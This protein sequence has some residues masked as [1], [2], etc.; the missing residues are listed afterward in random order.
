MKK[1]ISQQSQLLHQ[2]AA[3]ALFSFISFHID[4]KWVN[5]TSILF[6]FQLFCSDGGLVG[7]HR[8]ASLFSPATSLFQVVYKNSFSTIPATS[9]QILGIKQQNLRCVPVPAAV[10][11]TL[12][13]KRTLPL[14]LV[15]LSSVSVVAEF[16]DF[17]LVKGV[18]T[19]NTVIFTEP[20]LWQLLYQTVSCKMTVLHKWFFLVTSKKGVL[21]V[22][23]ISK[24]CCGK[25]IRDMLNLPLFLQYWHWT[26]S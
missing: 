22:R 11:L 2:I 3:L 24:L 8:A 5:F 17:F 13:N 10:S 4:Q 20:M 15:E 19:R 9:L 21:W 23:T 25:K 7:H 26:W 12:S 1:K 16:P 14:S 18:P 6:C